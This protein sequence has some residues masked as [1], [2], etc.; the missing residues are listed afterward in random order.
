MGFV[1]LHNHSQFTILNGLPSPPAFIAEAEKLEMP[2]ALPTFHFD[3]FL[4]SL[5]GSGKPEMQV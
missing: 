5:K 4:T 3:G 1:H 2:A